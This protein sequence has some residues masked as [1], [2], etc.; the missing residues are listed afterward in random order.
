VIAIIGILA[1][2]AIPQFTAYKKR[3]YVASCISDGKNALTGVTAWAGEN[4]ALIPPAEVITGV[5]AGTTYTTIKASAGNTITI[6]A[7]ASVGA[8]GVIT[9]TSSNL[10]GSLI[11]D[12]AGAQTHTLN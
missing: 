3:G 1:A 4:T 9:V 7:G 11:V 12:A 5:P 2:I 6:A 10:T 8:P